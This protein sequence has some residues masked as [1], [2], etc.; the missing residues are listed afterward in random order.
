MRISLEIG[1]LALERGFRCAGSQASPPPSTATTSVRILD[2]E[3]ARLYLPPYGLLAGEVAPGGTGKLARKISAD[4]E[5]IASSGGGPFDLARLQYLPP[6]P[7]SKPAEDDRSRS[8]S[9]Q[10]QRAL[11]M[12]RYAEEAS[13]K[14]G[15]PSRGALHFEVRLLGSTSAAGSYSRT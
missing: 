2:P 13:G 5:A 8:F 3:L 1:M 6:D 9:D 12:T 15:A 10:A 4:G 11:A 7:S 14:T